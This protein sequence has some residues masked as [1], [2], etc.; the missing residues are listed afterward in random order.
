MNQLKDRTALVTGSSRGIGAAIARKLAQAG[1][2]VIVHANKT[3][4]EAER[5]AQEIANKG[6]EAATVQGDLSSVAGAQ[7]VVRHAFSQFGALDILVNNAAVFHGDGV[8]QLDEEKIDA[9]LGVNIRSVLFTTKEFALLSKSSCGR[10]VNISSVAARLPSPGGSVYAATKAAVES[11]TRSHAVELGHRK[12]TVNAVAPGT[13]ETEMAMQAFSPDLLQLN[14]AVTPLGSLGQPEKIADVVAFLCS[15][16]A[17]WITGQLLGVDGGQ[18]TT[19][20]VLRRIQ[21]RVRMGMHES[22]T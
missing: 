21:E 7:Q 17:S 5:I 4:R 14:A 12:I 19:T 2:R 11:L 3:T 15:D 16:A 8:E 13:T 20:A 18:L 9:L 1:A 6:G 22:G 10:V